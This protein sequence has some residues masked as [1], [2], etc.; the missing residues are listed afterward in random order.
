M[1]MLSRRLAKETVGGAV[2]ELGCDCA[3][4]VLFVCKG[5]SEG[6]YVYAAET[7]GSSKGVLHGW[8]PSGGSLATV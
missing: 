5:S 8:K 7:V 1:G 4:A 3:S 2:G 6:R